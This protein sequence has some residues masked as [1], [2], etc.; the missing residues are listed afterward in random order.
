MWRSVGIWPRAASS[1]HI[2]PGK[3]QDSP[4]T[5]PMTSASIPVRGSARAPCARYEW[6]LD[7]CRIHGLAGYQ[8]GGTAP[9]IGHISS[10][11]SAAIPNPV[12]VAE[13]HSYI[14]ARNEACARLSHSLARP[15]YDSTRVAN[16]EGP[17]GLG[18]KTP[19]TRRGGGSHVCGFG[20]SAL[21]CSITKSSAG[22]A[23]RRALKTGPTRAKWSKHRPL[24]PPIPPMPPREAQR[25]QRR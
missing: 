8:L 2:F 24:A 14:C 10:A 16:G 15:S 1:H 3:C 17:P 18:S 22:L 5:T 13:R 4:E 12:P 21:P 25:Q 9:W 7:S 20:G 19:G 6:G 23:R 11:G